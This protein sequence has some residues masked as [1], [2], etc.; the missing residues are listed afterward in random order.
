MGTNILQA[1]GC[2]KPLECIYWLHSIM[3]HSICY[4]TS[5]HNLLVWHCVVQYRERLLPS[6]GQKRHHWL[7]CTPVKTSNVTG[8]HSDTQCNSS[9]SW[10]IKS[11][12]YDRLTD[13]LTL[14][15]RVLLDSN[16]LLCQW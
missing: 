12:G 13:S 7:I 4:C 6:S 3:L 9:H 8:G 2:S 16:Q 11:V 15:S 5:G 10:H 14:G 1:A